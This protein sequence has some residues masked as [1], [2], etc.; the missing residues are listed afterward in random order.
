MTEWPGKAGMLS[1]QTTVDLFKDS[2]TKV[3]HFQ[4]IFRYFVPIYVWIYQNGVK[5][6]DSKPWFQ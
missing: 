3:A 6:Q 5:E 2:G 4:T 1:F